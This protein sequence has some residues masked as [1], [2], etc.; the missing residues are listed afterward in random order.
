MK[1]KSVA[2]VLVSVILLSLV[3]PLKVSAEEASSRAK[4]IKD[5]FENMNGV[6]KAPPNMR[7]TEFANG[8]CAFVAMS[9]LLSYYDTYWNDTIVPETLEWQQG[10][11][12]SDT[13]EL[14][15]TFNANDEVDAWENRT[16]GTNAYVNA[17][18]DKYLQCYLIDMCNNLPIIDEFGVF[19]YQTQDILEYYLYDD[20]SFSR[21]EITVHL[22]RANNETDK[23]TMIN[24]AKELI[25][26]GHPV[27]FSG[28]DPI[29]GE[30]GNSTRSLGIGGHTMIGYDF[31]TLDDGKYDITVNLCWN[32]GEKQ[33]IRSSDFALFNS[34]IW[35]EIN[36]ENLPHVCSNNYVDKNDVNNDDDDEYF[37]SCDIYYNTHPEHK[38]HHDYKFNGFDSESH[39]I[40]CIC[41][42]KMNVE[43]HNLEYSLYGVAMHTESCI[44][45]GYIMLFDHNYDIFDTVSDGGHTMKCI[46]G[47][48]SSTVE[49]HYEAYGEYYTKDWHYVYCECGY[50]IMTD[51]HSMVPG[52]KLGTSRC[53]VC[54]YI[55]NN[56]GL[57][58]VIKGIED[59]AETS[60]E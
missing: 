40:N 5:H 24:T 46:C 17:N 26:D 20:K 42:Y 3:L 41:G 16:V 43:A 14:T 18:K 38:Y 11:Y 25:E 35:L 23:E 27:I 52:W 59:E 7:A 31:T 30:N 54:G 13:D 1:N 45:C 34:I 32:D 37:C 33:N 48:E 39:Y 12:D 60:T 44:D 4:M 29:I 19:A 21:D 53:T 15:A 56:S 51:T 6:T 58:E 8:S 55:R 49:P 47:K 10:T 57:I 28:F 36:E 2:V 9:M 50:L 22:Y